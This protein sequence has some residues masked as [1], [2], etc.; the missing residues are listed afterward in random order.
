MTIENKSKQSFYIAVILYQSSADVLDYQPLYQEG[1]FLLKATSLEEAKKKALVY[2]KQQ[3]VS[4]QNE[5]GE[6]ITWFFKQIV[7]VNSLLYNELEDGTELSA[8][9]F[10]N[11]EAYKQLDIA[12][13]SNL[14]VIEK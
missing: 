13:L 14:S 2:A 5:A 1:F 10:Q 8:R 6:T 3:E 11:Y 9:H 7:D 4:Y 12:G